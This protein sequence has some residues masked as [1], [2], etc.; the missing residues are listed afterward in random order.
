MYKSDIEIAQAVKMKP[1][2]EIAKKANDS[3]FVVASFIKKLRNLQY[4]ILLPD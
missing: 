2:T 4:Q 1:I 3:D